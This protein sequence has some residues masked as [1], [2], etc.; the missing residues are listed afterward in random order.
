MASISSASRTAARDLE[1]LVDAQSAR[2]ETM[3]AL[4]AK[5]GVSCD[6][7]VAAAERLAAALATPPGRRAR[8]RLRVRRG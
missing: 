6:E 4:A 8:R 2:L 7:A 1:R 5:P 3:R